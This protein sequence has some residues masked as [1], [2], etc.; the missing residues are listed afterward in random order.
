MRRLR[1]MI[2]L[3]IDRRLQGRMDPSDVIQESFLE[4]ASR[5][6]DY[7]RDPTLPFY[8]W[9]RFITLQK[10][11]ELHRH[12]LGVQARDA[13]RE[14]SLHHGPLPEATSAVLAAQLLGRHTTPSQAAIRAEMRI[15]LEEALNTMDPLDHE[16]LV[17]RH[18]EQLSNAETA[19]ALGIKPTAACNRYV[20]ALERLR[21]ILTG[22]ARD[23]GELSQ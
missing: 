16:V 18:F 22:T 10:L 1:R 3:R 15:R 23:V 6:G 2:R 8:V 19:R 13:A 5:L 12:H 11:A 21:K 20:R 7:L 9:L 14:V 4:A 17:L